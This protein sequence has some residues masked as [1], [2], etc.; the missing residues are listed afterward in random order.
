LM[1]GKMTNDALRPLASNTTSRVLSDYEDPARRIEELYLI[2]LSRRPT[3]QEGQ[4][5]I[6]YVSQNANKD[7]AYEDVLWSLMNSHEFLF[8]H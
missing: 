8:N 2:T 3:D 5:L 4:K 6:A 1:N 7:S